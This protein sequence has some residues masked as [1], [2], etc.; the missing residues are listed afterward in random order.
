MPLA[1]LLQYARFLKRNR[2]VLPGA[3]RLPYSKACNCE[4]FSHA[5][6]RELIRDAFPHDLQRFGNSF[7]LGRA[8]RHYWQ[9][10]MTARAFADHGILTR[11][12]QVLGVGAGSDPILFWLTQHVGQVFAA[13]QYLNKTTRAGTL[14]PSMLADPDR[15]WP[16]SWK[17]QRLVVQHLSCQDL[18]YSGES[19]EA[20]FAP[21]ALESCASIDEVECCLEN[22][23]R[24]LK[25][26]GI[27]S[28]TV[29]FAVEGPADLSSGRL[30]DEP[31][32]RQRILK[33]LPWSLIGDLDLVV[34][35][36][37]CQAEQPAEQFALSLRRHLERH[38]QL[39]WHEIAD[40]CYPHLAVRD[41]AVLSVPVHLALR[42]RG[43][44]V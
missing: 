13:D 34:S 29:E 31:A 17:R 19:F 16:G 41:G 26:G 27:V 24:V 12:A 23:F 15:H 7:P 9:T 4:D 5:D 40:N 42:K 39:L 1:S 43:R 6:V 35:E 18:R 8:A 28:L 36:A 38:G 20:V 37:T 44:M 11:R 2:E 22:L 10:A 3:D 21:H 25:P 14:C 30:F 33:H 32:I